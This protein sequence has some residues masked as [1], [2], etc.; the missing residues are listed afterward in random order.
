MSLPQNRLSSA[1]YL[2]ER[3]YYATVREVRKKYGNSIISILIAVA[4]TAVFT[5]PFYVMFAITPTRGLT[6]R[7]DFLVYNVA[8]ISVNGVCSDLADDLG[9]GHNILNTQVMSGLALLFGYYIAIT[10]FEI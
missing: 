3:I 6:I 9:I 1:L 8:G 4:R 10:K 2:A 7:R 5:L